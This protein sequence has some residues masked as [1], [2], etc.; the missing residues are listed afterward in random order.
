[1]FSYDIKIL[2]DNTISD[3][4]RGKGMSSLD[5]LLKVLVAII[6]FYLIA[7][8]LRVIA[9]TVQKRLDKKNIDQ[10]AS[11]FVINLLRYGIL[12]LSLFTIVSKLHIVEA[13]SIAALVASAGV[14][15]S[16][17]MQGAL[18][19]LAGGVLLLIIRPFKKGD[20]IEIPNANVEGVVEEIAIY[21]TT[22]QTVAGEI[23]K[24]PNA[25]LT[26]NSVK[27]R[28]GNAIRALVINVDV[29]YDTE[30]DKARELVLGL[31]KEEDSVVEGSENIFVDELGQHGV[32]LGVLMMV[33]VT[34]YLSVKRSLNEKIL[35]SFRENNIEIPFNK[36]D[37]TLLNK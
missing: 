8:V 23:I 14:G 3:W 19:N 25:Q 17:A 32:R 13:A 33:P 9:V 1:M 24:I 18:S 12:I 30:I 2:D 20:Y 31:I 6:V 35:K 4:I 7:K 27:N 29:D 36:L 28:S 22:I 21:Y 10:T 11:H 16:L 5:Y 37:V 15:I 26:N 34:S